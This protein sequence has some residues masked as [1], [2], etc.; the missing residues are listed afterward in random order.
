LKGETLKIA[1]IQEEMEKNSSLQ[2]DLDACKAKVLS[3][4]KALHDKLDK[5]E[6][7]PILLLIKDTKNNTRLN[8]N[9]FNA[10]KRKVDSEL[11]KI[12]TLQDKI[13]GF[14]GKSCTLEEFIKLKE[15][16]DQFKGVNDE[17]LNNIRQYFNSK[18]TLKG[19]KDWIKKVISKLKEAWKE[20]ESKERDRNE[21]ILTRK[22]INDAQCGS[23]DKKM[24]ELIPEKTKYRDWNKVESVAENR[25]KK[26]VSRSISNFGKG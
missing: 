24:K 13:E 17:E 15:T 14:K 2:V 10:Y 8:Y 4:S 12:V 5:S 23:C 18:L 3:V 21:A 25:G 11:I 1:G 6:K 16:V 7:D 19:D 22:L 20:F 26:E 9:E